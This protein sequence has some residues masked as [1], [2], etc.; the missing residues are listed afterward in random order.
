MRPD[1]IPGLFNLTRETKMAGSEQKKYNPEICENAR[2]DIKALK[3]TVFG[4][5][6]TGQVGL[7]TK[8]EMFDEFRKEF[9]QVFNNFVSQLTVKLVIAVISLILVSA[10]QIIYFTVKIENME[11]K[12]ATPAYQPGPYYAKQIKM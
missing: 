5:G 6:G 9:K 2:T 1:F 3:Q 4:N 11:K 8:V 10:G 12:S 7:N